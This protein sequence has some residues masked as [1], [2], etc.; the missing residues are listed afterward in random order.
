M[1]TSK[2]DPA[3]RASAPNT[4]RRW[5]VR[6]V[7]L[8]LLVVA[9][10]MADLVVTWLR[11]SPRIRKLAHEYPGLTNQMQREGVIAPPRWVALED[12][13]GVLACAVLISEDPRFLA[14]SGVDWRRQV[15]IVRIMMEGDRSP[16]GSGIAQQL[17]RTLYLTPG[18]TPR[19]KLR[20]WLLAINIGR[21]LSRERQL[22]LYLNV[23]QWGPA[24][25]GVAQGAEDLLGK[26]LDQLTSSDAV[27]LAVVLPAP[28]RGFD[29]AL[30]PER[31]SHVDRLVF[32]LWERG[33][34]D[35]V[36]ASAAG[37]RLHEWIG[38]SD[39]AGSP[40]AGR[41]RMTML[42]GEELPWR[43]APMPRLDCAPGAR[44][45]P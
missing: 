34:L 28:R 37:A 25:W 18:L 23:A 31:R 16:G 40:E 17:A 33:V 45:P 36:E 38:A 30:R 12:V 26:A 24:A 10:G 2:P 5:A 20:E 14:Y 21:T 13:P 19:R 4:L 7:L 11:Y 29:F 27:L 15:Q 32:R 39:A 35:D 6:G 41:E 22:E 1:T 43:G 3:P 8:L 9:L 44:W 42:L